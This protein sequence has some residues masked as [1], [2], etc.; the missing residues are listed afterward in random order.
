MD[1]YVDDGIFEDG[2]AGGSVDC[3]FV[4]TLRSVAFE[5]PTAVFLV[6]VDLGRVVAFVEEL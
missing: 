1:T 2:D 5:I 3:V 6:E 4:G